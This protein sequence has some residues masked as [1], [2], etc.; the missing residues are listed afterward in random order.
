VLDGFVDCRAFA[1]PHDS[2]GGTYGFHITE[3]GTNAALAIIMDAGSWNKDMRDA[4]NASDVVL[5]G[6]DYDDTLVENGNYNDSLKDRIASNTGH[7]SNQA[8][9]DFVHRDWNGRAHTWILAHLSEKRNNPT[10][11][12]TRFMEVC[13]PDCKPFVIVSTKDAPTALISVELI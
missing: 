12:Y 7:M 11:A 13:R 2:S 9:Q 4:A 3:R 5:I 10:L 8:L 6:V 1:V